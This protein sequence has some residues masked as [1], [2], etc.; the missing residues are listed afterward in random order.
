MTVEQFIADLDE[1]VAWVCARLGKT[2]VTILGHSWGSALGTLYAARFPH[3]VAVYVG[4]AQIGDWPTAE[5]VSYAFA[6]AEAERLGND[7]AIKELRAIGA[8]PYSAS[9]VMTERTWLSRFDGQMRPK[10]LVNI[11][12]IFIGGPESTVVDLPNIIRGFQF[13]LDAMWSEVSQ[14]NLVN[15]VPALQM[16]VFFFVGRRDHWVPPETSVAYFDTLKAPSK[17]LV[18]FDESAHEQFVDEPAKFNAT[19]L[20]LV[21]PV[22][23]NE[24]QFAYSIA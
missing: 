13:T 4:T 1:L 8:P 15:L 11:G 12:R 20:E 19:M 6:L 16:P 5:A 14:L 10:A 2:Q 22:V 24:P 23:V 17:T 7:R 9:A 3:K 21:L 18:W